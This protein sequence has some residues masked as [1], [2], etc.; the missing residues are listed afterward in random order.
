MELQSVTSKLL[1]LGLELTCSMLLTIGLSMLRLDFGQ[2]LS[3][4]QCGSS[5]IFQ[6]W[7]QVSVLMK[8]GLNL[9]RPMTICEELTFGA[10]QSTYSS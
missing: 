8:C 5:I 1:R 2:W 4:M 3:I 6:E 7:I 9:A 10:A